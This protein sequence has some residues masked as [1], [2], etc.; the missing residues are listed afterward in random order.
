V[1][2]LV[3]LSLVNCIPAETLRREIESQTPPVRHCY[4]EAL[5]EEGPDF[6]GRLLIRFV[7]SPRGTVSE[8]RVQESQ[9][10]SK[11]F[12]AC[13]L[14]A[15]KTWRFPKPPGG[16]LIVINYPFVFKPA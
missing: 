15:V 6:S 9:L 3:L 2:T 12:Q 16:G 4:E 7:V 14:A 11:K 1:H 13:V 10:Q 5:R 8:A